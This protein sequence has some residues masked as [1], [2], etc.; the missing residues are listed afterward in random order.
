[1]S[2]PVQASQAVATS[3]MGAISPEVL[4]EIER[5]MAAYH[6]RPD[7]LIQVLHR[8]QSLLGYLPKEAL[9]YIGERMKLPLSH[10]YG[11]VTFYHFFSTVPKGRHECVVCM[12]TACYVKG[13][14]R[15]VDRLE[16]HLGIK[17]GQTTPDLRYTVQV[18]RCIGACSLAPAVIIDGKVHSQMTPAA[19]L[20][21]LR[22]L[23]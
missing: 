22:R 7:A 11:V 20:R 1:M 4:E 3:S 13:A 16:Q 17:P 8:T 9:A 14:E 5:V 12:G 15:I 2:I 10:I 18:A 21:E 23:K 6:Y 19:V